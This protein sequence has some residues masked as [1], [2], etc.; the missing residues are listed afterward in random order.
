[1]KIKEVVKIIFVVVVIIGMMASY[2]M[3]GLQSPSP[4]QSSQEEFTGPVGEPTFNGPTYLP[5]EEIID[6]L[7]E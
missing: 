6:T 3:I 7:S 4:I 5:S 2:V 1:M